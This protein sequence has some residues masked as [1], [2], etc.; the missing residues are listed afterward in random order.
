MRI[1][2]KY[3]SMQ[4]SKSN[5]NAP[6][7]FIVGGTK[8]PK[9]A[10]VPPNYYPGD[11][12]EGRDGYMWK[13][14]D[15]GYMYLENFNIYCCYTQYD[16]AEAFKECVK[17][18][19]KYGIS[20]E[21]YILSTFSAGV[22]TSHFPDGVLS[23][24]TPKDWDKI[25]FAGAYISG[26]WYQYLDNMIDTIHKAGAEKVHYFTLGRIDKSSEGATAQAKSRLIKELPPQNV[27]INKGS[28]IDQVRYT[29][30]FINNSY[31]I[32]YV[33]NALDSSTLS[34][35]GIEYNKK[36]EAHSKKKQTLKVKHKT[37]WK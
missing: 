25:I 30:I 26:G 7:I 11:K 20:P 5:K 2:G 21:K 6:L 9:K 16:S 37:A 27:H 8:Y 23:Q 24:T 22:T 3:G 13:W 29:S 33:D 18:L 31:N 36:Q 12:L 4:V 28:H 1:R 34:F 32:K 10:S 15:F 19:I 17:F 35:D 14:S